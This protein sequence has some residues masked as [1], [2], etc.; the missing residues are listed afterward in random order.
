MNGTTLNRLSDTAQLLRQLDLVITVDTAVAHLAGALNKPTWVLLPQ[1]ADF[2]WLRQRPDTPGI[3]PCVC[4]ASR[5]MDWQSVADQLDE[6]FDTMLRWIPRLWCQ[7]GWLMPNPLQALFESEIA[8]LVRA[9]VASPVGSTAPGE[10]IVEQVPIPSN[11]LRSN[12]RL[13]W[14]INLVRRW[15]VVAGVSSISISISSVPKRCDV[16]R[17]N[18]SVLA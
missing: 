6:A 4:F 3:P 15:R 18:A 10:L 7:R 1:N 5:P 16:S 9:W 11:G 8:A 17:N 13:C 2:R 12:V 14:A